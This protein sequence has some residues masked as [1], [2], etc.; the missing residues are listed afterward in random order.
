MSKTDLGGVVK[1]KLHS[2]CDEN[3]CG[4]DFWVDGSER[5]VEMER[6]E[7][8]IIPDAFEDECF[9]DSF[10]KTPIKYSMTG[11]T[12]QIASA[13]NALGGGTNWDPGAKVVKNGR[14]MKVPRKV[15]YKFKKPFFVEGGSVVINRTNML[16]PKVHTFEGS[17]YEI[18]SKINS[19]GGNGVKLVDAQGNKL[20]SGGKIEEDNQGGDCYIV[21]GRF[22]MNNVDSIGGNSFEGTPYL[23]HAQVHGQGALQGIPYGHAFIEDDEWIYDFSNGRELIIPKDIYYLIGKIQTTKP[24]HYK[25]TFEEAKRKM[26]ETGTYGSWDLET[27]SGL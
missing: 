18:A 27:E 6:D 19:Y 10:C 20:K 15:G 13:I 11:T 2:E 7:A 5:Q 22:A 4:V 1:G 26:V 14:K 12:S 25:Y 9:R 16:S 3:G 23:V 24:R 17:T 21:A 8:V